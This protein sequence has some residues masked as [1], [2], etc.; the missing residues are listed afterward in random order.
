M[1]R[2][3]QTAGIAGTVLTPIA[4][5]RLG[6]HGVFTRQY[7]LLFPIFWVLCM[8]TSYY[9]WEEENRGRAK[10]GFVIAALFGALYFS[11]PVIME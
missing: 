2:A 9:L 10:A 3:L 11:M 6:L 7:A 1:A 4:E 5:I 8:G